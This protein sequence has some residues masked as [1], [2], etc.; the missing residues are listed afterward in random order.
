DVDEFL[1]RA[2]LPPRW[3]HDV[4]PSVE[5]LFV[6]FV[7]KERKARLREQLRALASD[8]PLPSGERAG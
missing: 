2:G 1:T 5:D 3:V 7:D 8:T 4:E 6:S